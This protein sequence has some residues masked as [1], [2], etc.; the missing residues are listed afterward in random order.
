[1]R[2]LSNTLIAL[3][4]QPTN[5]PIWL[6]RIAIDTDTAN[7]IYLAEYD[8]DVEFFKV[9]D[10]GSMSAQTYLAF[11]MKHGGI[12][13]NIVNQV[14]GMTISIANVSREIQAL[15]ELYDGLRGMKVTV[16]QVFASL[17][18]NQDD[19]I[20]DVYY[21]DSVNS[22]A[23]SATFHLMP[24]LDAMKVNLPGRRYLRNHCPNIYEG[25]GCYINNG[26]GTFS[27][28]SG[29]EEAK[30]LIWDGGSVGAISTDTSPGAY[31][32]LH[33][34]RSQ[35]YI[36]PTTD[37]LKIDLKCSDASKLLD[38]STGLYILYDYTGLP[39]IYWSYPNTN[40]I[41]SLTSSWTTFTIPFADFTQGPP[42][43]LI[44]TD[45]VGWTIGS[46][47]EVTIAFR[48]VY[49]YRPQLLGAPCEK[50]LQACGQRNNT[51]RFGGFPNIPGKRHF[52]A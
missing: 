6:Y 20:E 45:M 42:H 5:D 49:L 39:D 23:T 28:P 14:E 47:S 25:R 19:Y 32:Y 37:Y 10:D 8:G 4:N 43:I 7:D 36:D 41:P 11:P 27:A 1:V 17:L 2:T 48:H 44:T 31:V 33:T 18:A 9:N 40:L 16:W 29:F 15:I 30:Q 26:D 46:S 51:A 21:V 22:N 38:L 34:V 35:D 50:T 24:K 3:K 12:G 52:R 13:E